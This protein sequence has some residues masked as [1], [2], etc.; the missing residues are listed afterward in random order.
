MAK[1]IVGFV[2]SPREN[3]NTA[4]IVEE[5]ARAARE[6]GAQAKVYYLN[7]MSFKPCQGCFKCREAETCALDDDMQQ[8]YRDLQ[9]AAAVVIGSPVYMGQVTG[10]TKA[11]L[12]RLFP[13]IGPDF[14]PRFG[15]KKAALVFSQGLPQTEAYK[16]Y[17]ENLASGLRLLGLEV[18]A[19]LV[20]AGANEPHKA[21]NDPA[22]LE[23]ARATGRKLAGS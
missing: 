6:Q 16:S 22:L 21:Q 14:K 11:F 13:I 5:V 19:T 4:T 15:V 2:G 18:V 7:T 12:D 8:V 3:G 20:C 23:Q 17:F 10:Q 1:K 9:D